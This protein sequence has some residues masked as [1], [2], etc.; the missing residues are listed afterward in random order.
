MHPHQYIE[1][2]LPL[3]QA[4]K[5]IVFLHGRGGTAEDIMT[6][7]DVLGD[8]TF[9]YAAPQAFRNTWYPYSFLEDQVFN[10]PWLSSALAVID[11]QVDRIT[12]HV[13]LARIYLVG[14]SQGA[15]LALEAAARNA[16]A[17][18]GVVAFTGGLIGKVLDPSKY[19][20]DFKGCPVFIGNSDHD[21]HVP[22]ERS[23]ASQKIMKALNGEV[24]LNVYPGMAHTINQ[25]EIQWVNQHVLTCD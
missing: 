18:G 13:P 12:S 2:G 10:E 6:L 3:A 24:T 22:L 23:E 7:A 20:G 15:C 14:F 19:Q 25:D 11:E 1:K 17:Y 8:K 16:R 5:A 9:Y 4:Q 21:P